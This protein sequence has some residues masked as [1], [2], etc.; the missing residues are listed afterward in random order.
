[1]TQEQSVAGD[2]RPAERPGERP[3]KW[4]TRGH[5]PP[6]LWLAVGLIVPVSSLLFRL[7]YRHAERIPARGP[8]LLVANHVSILDPLSCARLVWDNGRVPHFLAKQSVFNAQSAYV[9]W[10]LRSRIKL[11]TQYEFND[12]R[13]FPTGLRFANGAPKTAFF[14]FPTPFF[15]DTRRGLARA[16]FWGQVRSDAQRSVVI[17]IKRGAAFSTVA[18]LTTDAGG[19]FTRVMRAQR[20]ATY[21][22]Q[23]VTSAGTTQTS[24]TFRT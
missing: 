15:I 10:L 8:V 13:T 23:Y 5:I 19:Y 6:A 9:S 14:T 16:R 21:R 20:R 11:L 4:R 7:R 1:M 2:A 22:F 18:T 12:D 24:Q 3:S 17:Q